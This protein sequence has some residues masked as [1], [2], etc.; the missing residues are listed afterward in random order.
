MSAGDDEM[1]IG[2]SAA[3]ITELLNRIRSAPA[4]QAP[5]GDVLSTLAKAITAVVPAGK[6][7][8]VSNDILRA[9]DDMT[10]PPDSADKLRPHFEKVGFKLEP[11]QATD[12]NNAKKQ[13]PYVA[14]VSSDLEV[15][16][17]HLPRWFLETADGVPFLMFTLK[18]L[19]DRHGR[20]I[21]DS[22]DWI[23]PA[24][25][26]HLQAL[27]V[28]QYTWMFVPWSDFKSVFL[29]QR[30][31]DV[32][33]KLTAL[34][35]AGKMNGAAAPPPSKPS[36]D[37]IE[38]IV[39]FLSELAQN[40]ENYLKGLVANAELPN[41]IKDRIKAGFRGNSENDVRHLL[42][43][44]LVANQYPANHEKAGDT[45]LGR[46]LLHEL[47]G[48]GDPAGATFAKIIVDRALVQ[49]KED[50]VKARARLGGGD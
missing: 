9:L 32:A 39:G 5:A 1:K 18:N 41:P 38:K 43:V 47:E 36:D 13:R 19:S 26:E 4:A 22:V 50:L 20:I 33:L 17:L 31:I 46:M 8:N 34:R 24:Y 49:R 2:L 44:L 12:Q 11:R 48:L 45:F 35:V 14:A 25:H 30:T 29:D 27:S 15:V 42:K 28:R 37:E 21:S 23:E 3:D 16:V 10:I 40:D 6:Q 7:Q